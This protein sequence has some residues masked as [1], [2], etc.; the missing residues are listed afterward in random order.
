MSPVFLMCHLSTVSC[1]SGI[2]WIPRKWLSLM[3]NLFSMTWRTST[4]VRCSA[5]LPGWLRGGG[6]AHTGTHT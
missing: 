6:T 1:L 2:F 3:R 4:P 5:V